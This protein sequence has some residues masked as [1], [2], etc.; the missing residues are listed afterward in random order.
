M[1][2]ALNTVYGTY[3]RPL[4]FKKLCIKFEKFE[5]QQISIEVNGDVAKKSDRKL[6]RKV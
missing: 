5:K 1:N 6:D 2:N 4:S 3:L